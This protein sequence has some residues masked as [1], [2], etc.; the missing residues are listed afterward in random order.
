MIKPKETVHLNPPN[1]IKGDWMIGL[2][3][4]EVYNS[5]FNINTT[6]NEFKHYT[7]TFD[8]ISFEDLKDELEEIFDFSNITDDHLEDEIIGPRIIETYKKLVTQKRQNDAYIILSNSYA[9]S[10]FRD[11]ESYL[12]IVIG[13]DE[14][15][16]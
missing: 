1:Q 4:L 12:R 9:T 8:E 7:D 5:I 14:D 2:T 6:H 10:P 16:I 15:D 13:L 11:S 3:S